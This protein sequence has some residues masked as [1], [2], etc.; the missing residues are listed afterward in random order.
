MIQWSNVYKRDL[1]GQNVNIYILIYD[2]YSDFTNACPTLFLHI[3]IAEKHLLQSSFMQISVRSNQPVCQWKT[4]KPVPAWLWDAITHARCLLP[5]SAQK[6]AQA[7]FL[8]PNHTDRA[9]HTQWYSWG[10]ALM[11]METDSH[12]GSTWDQFHIYSHSWAFVEFYINGRYA[13]E[14]KVWPHLSIH[15]WFRPWFSLVFWERPKNK[16]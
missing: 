1:K 11:G 15:Y 2:Q 4:G 14:R 5:L 3:W 12:F 9:W 7:V 10:T 8:A 16:I 13:H 6:V